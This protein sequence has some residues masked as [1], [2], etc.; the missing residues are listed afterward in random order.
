MINLFFKLLE[1]RD[2][3][4]AEAKQAG[5]SDTFTQVKTLKYVSKG[6]SYL[7]TPACAVGLV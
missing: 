7:L 4:A 3:Q 2:M 6:A 1:A 5:R